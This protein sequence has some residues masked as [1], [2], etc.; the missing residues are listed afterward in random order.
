[1][2]LFSLI[3]AVG[4]LV[5]GAVVVIE[6]ADRQL[7]EGRDPKD[8]YKIAAQRMAWPIISST[9]TTLAVFFPLLFWPGMVGE[10]M[11]FLPITLLATLIASLLMALVFVPL[12]G[13]VMSKIRKQPSISSHQKFSLRKAKGLTKYYLSG[14]K[15]VLRHPVKTISVA[16]LS[17]IFIGFLTSYGAKGI[18]FFPHVEPENVMVNIHLTGSLSVEQQDHL[19][20]KIEAEILTFPYFKSVY[21]VAGHSERPSGNSSADD[22]IG[23][24]Q[25]E[26]KEWDQ[27]PSA[28]KIFEMIQKKAEAYHGLYIEIVEERQ[29]PSSDKPIHLQVSSVY[30]ELLEDTTRKIV[31]Y[32][33][34]DA[35]LTAIEDTRPSPG[36]EWRLDVDRAIAQRYGVDV[37]AVGDM[38]KL[39][40]NVIKLSDYTPNNSDDKIDIILRYPQKNHHLTQ[41]DTLRIMTKEGAVPLSYFV[42]RVAQNKTGIIERIETVRSFQVKA[43]VKK[44]VLTHNKIKDIQK[45]EKSQNFSSNVKIIYKGETE[46]QKET[47]AFLFKAFFIALF[48]MSLILVTQFNSFYHTFLILSSIVLS[49]GGVMIGLLVMQTPFSIVMNGI[50]LIALAGIVVNN[51][52][53]L[54]DTYEEL[55]RKK[56]P[57]FKALLHTGAERLR[58]ILLT[59]GTT[60]LGLVPMM[61]GINIDFIS[62]EVSQGAPSTQFW[63]QLSASIVFG[64]GFATF[65]TLFVTPASL[66]VKEYRKSKQTKTLPTIM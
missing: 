24:I 4:M 46:D 10:F 59:A 62:R 36:I 55:K 58:P 60:I 54:I 65:L 61:F 12:L 25:I 52:I 51:N 43:D 19:V 30:P 38:I 15:Y 21:T 8:A 9:A 22:I 20:K 42:K 1:M 47:G 13:A 5:D 44:G 63:T 23:V 7:A 64:L 17:L 53:I 45:W 48:M 41:L 16:F 3:L 37:T 26:L 14:L 2:V 11:K 33:E 50:G 34:A 27:R 56:Y 29:G 49:A 39:I 57:V 40:T 66:L 32:F 35:D 28:D 31:H 18:E 6:Y